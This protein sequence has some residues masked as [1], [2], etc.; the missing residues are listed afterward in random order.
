MSLLDLSLLLFILFTALVNLG[1]TILTYRSQKVQIS[2]MIDRIEDLQSK[3][4]T[5]GKVL[6]IFE[7]ETQILQRRNEQLSVKQRFNRQQR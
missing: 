2:F 3:I 6:K 4:G 5:L 1:F 7:E